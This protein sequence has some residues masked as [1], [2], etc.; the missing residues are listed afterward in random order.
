MNEYKDF[1]IFFKKSCKLI[2]YTHTRMT[3]AEEHREETLDKDEQDQESKH[4]KL[5]D[6]NQ[7]K[8]LA[9]VATTDLTIP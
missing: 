8:S 4:H 2:S 9:C 1:F 7:L 3:K 6:M 5:D